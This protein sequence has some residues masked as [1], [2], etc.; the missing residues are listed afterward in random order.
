MRVTLSLLFSHL[1]CEYAANDVEKET[2]CV[3]F[4]SLCKVC[5]VTQQEEREEEEENQLR[6]CYSEVVCFMKKKQINPGETKSVT[7]VLL[8]RV[9]RNKLTRQKCTGRKRQAQE[10]RV[11]MKE[12]ETER[13]R[14]EER[15]KSMAQLFL[16]T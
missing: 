2:V 12:T 6:R 1:S 14:G 16:F 9:Q 11:T 7:T 13:E 3:T 15:K 4:P 10:T 5:H 8:S